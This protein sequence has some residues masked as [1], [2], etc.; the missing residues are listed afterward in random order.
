MIGEFNQPAEVHAFAV[1]R[2]PRFAGLGK[3][4]FSFS[5]IIACNEP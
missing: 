1:I 2:L 4:G 3:K 5:G